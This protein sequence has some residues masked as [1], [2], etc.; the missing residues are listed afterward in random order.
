M[1]AAMRELSQDL[2]GANDRSMQD[3]GSADAKPYMNMGKPLGF[4]DPNDLL[5]VYDMYG[6]SVNELGVL[7]QMR[8]THDIICTSIDNKVALINSLDFRVVPRKE[9]P[10]VSQ[11][12]AAEAVNLLLTTMPGRSLSNFISTTYDRVYTYGFSCYEIWFPSS[13]PGANKLHL[14]E[15]PQNQIN[16]WNA[17]PSRFLI[18]SVQY[19]S[20]TDVPIIPGYKLAW[21]GRESFPG[22]FWGTSELRKLLALFQG[23]SEDLRN[24]LS[25]RRLQKGVLYF[26]ETEAANTTASWNIAKEFLRNY[27]SGRTSPLILPQSMGINHLNADSPGL[28]SYSTMLEYFDRKIKEALDSS[29]A[30]LGVDG[31]SYALAKELNVKDRERVA[32]H[33]NS[34]LSLMNGDTSLN[35]HLLKTLTHICG[36]NPETDTPKFEILDNSAVSLTTSIE[37]LDT[38]LTKGVIE[39]EDIDPEDKALLLRELGFKDETL[40]KNI[41]DKSVMPARPKSWSTREAS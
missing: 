40:K 32:I 3:F 6:T 34:F 38:L 41:L 31:G 23:Y 26:Q 18:E 24:Y 5:S 15:I 13:G 22:N 21:F 19:V 36:F 35:T 27:Y 39:V 25:L 9:N 2:A 16:Y 10:T 1:L 17:D 20:G 33:V 28:E 8:Y 4:R 30:N 11:I 12:L 7:A 37:V 14:L 29:L